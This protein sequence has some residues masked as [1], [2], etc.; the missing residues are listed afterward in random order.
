[1]EVAAGPL[2]AISIADHTLRCRIWRDATVSEDVGARC[3][4]EIS[5]NLLARASG[6]TKDANRILLDVRKGPP[7]FGPKTEATLRHMF[8]TA[9]A[10]EFPIAVVVG[11]AMQ[12]LQYTRLR[13]E[14]GETWFF[15]TSD[16]DEAVAYLARVSAAEPGYSPKKP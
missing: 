3:A 15:V 12:E 2:Y 14:I 9:A 1:M 16:E 8:E 13:T 4:A 10:N 5:K 6:T 7:A 11:K